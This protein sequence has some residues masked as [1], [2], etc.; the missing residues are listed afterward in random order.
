MKRAVLLILA[1]VA[2]PA[3]ALGPITHEDVWLMKRVGTPV[4]SPDGSLLVVSVTEPAYDDEEKE[5]DL[6]IITTDGSAKPRRLTSSSG[7][8]GGIAWS[9]DGSRIAF[10]T[11]R[12]DD[13]EDQ[14]Y[15]MDMTG[16]GEARRLTDLSTGASTP[17]WSPDGKHLAFES[18]VFPGAADDE[19]NQEE[20][21]KLEERE[22]NA[23]V[24]DGFPIRHWDHWRDE[25]QVHLFV[26]PVDGGGEARDLFAGTD[27]VAGP[28]YSGSPSLSGEELE[29]AWTPDGS[30]LVFVATATRDQA[31][32]AFVPYSLHVISTEG[33]E[34]ERLTGD[35]AGFGQPTFSPDGRYLYSLRRPITDFAYNLTRIARFEWPEPGSLEVLAESFDRPVGD[36]VFAPNG[37]SVYAIA[38]DTG[39]RRIFEIAADGS[40]VRLLDDES[41]GVYAGP[42][43]QGSGEIPTLVARWEDSTH[44]AEIVRVDPETGQHES[45]SSF[46]V[47]RAAGIDWWPFEDFW[48]ESSK[49]RRIHNWLVLPPNFD[50][51]KKYPLV[52]AIHGGPHSTWLDAGHVRWHPQLMASPGYVVLLTDYTGSVGY[53]EEFARL[54]Q[55]DPLRTPGQELEEVA[56]EVI[57]RF[58]FVDSTRQAALGASYGGHLVNWLQATTTRFKCLVGHAGLI[59]LEGQWSTSDA[60]F[61]REINNGGPPWEGSTIWRDQSPATYAGDFQTPILLTIGEKD[62]RVPLN[63]TLGAWAYV[64]RMNIPSRLI[65]F[66]DAN[67]WIMKGPDAKFFWDEVFAWLDQYLA[68]ETPD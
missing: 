26:Q 46:N 52:L 6:W 35:D 61:H 20:A 42:Q 10:V 14:I 57:R 9:P 8:E 38:T 62:Y 2:V 30:A 36:F 37:D 1:L 23:S 47:G 64:Q 50:V 43:A 48:F 40:D 31:A 21:K 13:E 67:H 68:D 27:L 4:L 7:G 39:R 53:G 32:R 56:D 45:L 24:Y 12:E 66:H 59:S 55:G 17:V 65:V 22:Y 25:K 60:I 3:L 18:M 51:Y 34:P 44:P 11:K 16:P 63:Q 5:S 41:R 15:I 33:G 49:G 54:I 58:S 19:A 28:G 29:A